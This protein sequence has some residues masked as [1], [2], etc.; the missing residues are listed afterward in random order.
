MVRYM[1]RTQ[2][3]MRRRGPPT[4]PELKRYDSVVGSTGLFQA[5][6]FNPVPGL[7]SSVPTGGIGTW[8]EMLS[9]F[10]PASGL[11]LYDQNTAFSNVPE[12]WRQ[13]PTLVGNITRGVTSTQR[14]GEKIWVKELEIRGSVYGYPES[15][16]EAY[17][18]AI[19]SAADNLQ[20]APSSMFRMLVWVV[21]KN[22]QTS[23]STTTGPQSWPLAIA[24]QRNLFINQ[25]GNGVNSPFYPPA[26]AGVQILYDQTFSLGAN[27]DNSQAVEYPF[28]L[29][30]PVRKV[31]TYNTLTN[32]STT[33]PDPP[34]SND[35]YMCIFGDRS[36]FMVAS[37]PY[38]WQGPCPYG[39][40]ALVRTVYTDV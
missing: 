24:D 21:K 39:W 9:T 7:D 8:S 15:Y 19:G 22:F 28:H 2:R 12:G 4:T 37:D 18:T 36:R 16:L 27:G 17:R 3:K 5:S 29:K 23:N 32:P 38:C 33:A 35:I 31:V 11:T 40:K 6:T 34:M 30:I 13:C 20:N 1:R 10:C 25:A 26:K 14:I